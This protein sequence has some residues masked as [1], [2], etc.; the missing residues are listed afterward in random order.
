M[1]GDGVNILRVVREGLPEKVMS[2]LSPG[3]S[4]GAG[5]TLPEGRACQAEGTA[6]AT[7]LRR[8]STWCVPGS[9]G[10][11][12]GVLGKPSSLGLAHS[13]RE[14]CPVLRSVFLFPLVRE[15]RSTS[16]SRQT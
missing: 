8:K 15:V 16:F 10:I 1:R 2:E 14:R 11:N 3:G 4:E 5:R 13:A 6:R 9:Q 7:V 12:P